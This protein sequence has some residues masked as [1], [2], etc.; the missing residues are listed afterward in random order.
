MKEQYE[1][2]LMNNVALHCMYASEHGFSQWD[3]WKQMTGLWHCA[4][5]ASVYCL[6]GVQQCLGHLSEEKTWHIVTL[7]TQGCSQAQQ[8]QNLTQLNPMRV[9]H[10][11][12]TVSLLKWKLNSRGYVDNLLDAVGIPFGLDSIRRGFIFQDD[13]A[14]HMLHIL[15]QNFMR[16]T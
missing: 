13:K 6:H 10:T 3:H 14:T 8:L 9:S 15:L 5:M 2:L 12:N 11:R 1:L 16:K 4:H 7:G